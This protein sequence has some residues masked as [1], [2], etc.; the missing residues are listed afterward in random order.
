MS[1]DRQ[2][3]LLNV[4]EV[5]AEVGLSS[6]TIWNLRNAGKI[7]PPI[8]IGRA[9]RWKRS[10]IEQWIAQGCPDVSRAQRLDTLHQRTGR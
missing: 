9:I 6:R 2:T 4:N 1:S 3:L 8:R 10:D 7:P 5:G